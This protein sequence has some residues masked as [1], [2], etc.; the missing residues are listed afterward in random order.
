MTRQ[1]IPKA[2][3]SEART[4][5]DIKECF[6]KWGIQDYSVG[7]EAGSKVKPL[8]FVRFSI[9][10]NEQTIRCE[11]AWEY[12]ANLRAIYRL[13]ES[14]RMAAHYGIMEELATAAAAML[15]AGKPKRPAHEVLGIAENMDVEFAEAAHRTLAKRHH[16]D[17]GGSN[18][19]MQEINDALAEFKAARA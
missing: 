12:G 13:L 6:Q 16:P 5:R 7:G 14:L 8:A 4:R 10:G 11:R 1:K 17:V 2:Y 19:K 15:P 3:V 9:N 18:E